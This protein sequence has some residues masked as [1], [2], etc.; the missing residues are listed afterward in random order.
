MP[1]NNSAPYQAIGGDNHLEM[2]EA[3]M[4]RSPSF[5]A[6][7][8]PSRK[9]FA[10]SFGARLV[11]TVGVAAFLVIL[12]TTAVTSGNI[13]AVPQTLLATTSF[14]TVGTLSTGFTATDGSANTSWSTARSKLIRYSSLTAD[15]KKAEFVRYKLKFGRSYATDEE[16]QQRYSVFLSNLERIDAMNDDVS[17]AAYD[18]NEFAD[19]THEEFKKYKTGYSSTKSTAQLPGEVADWEDSQC[20]AC[21]RYPE[22]ADYT[23]ENLPT[24]FDWRDYGAVTKIKNQGMCGSC[25]SFS[26]TGDVEGSWYLAGNN[27]TSLAEQQLVAC[28]S[29]MDNGCNG[30]LPLLA[31]MYL[32]KAGGIVSEDDYP[33]MK[34]NQYTDAVDAPNCDVSIVQKAN[35]AAHISSW[36]RISYSANTEDEMALALIR[37]GPLSAAL[38]ATGM[39]YYSG[40][41]D[42]Y[43]GCSTSL[44]HAVLI[45][46]FGEED[47]V[48]YWT[49]KN[50]WGILWGEEGT[51]RLKRGE[52]TC[53]IATEVVHSLV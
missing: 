43:S 46:G 19:M 15:L 34:A 52:N 20:S 25:W 30:G 1:V 2:Q 49:I 16:E 31:M 14:E 21:K 7:P 50:S 3:G 22:M 38:D 27:L 32:E 13:G 6:P 12:G 4:K 39:E 26:T 37:S 48:K 45:V 33:Y 29:T 36:Q 5:S 8:S 18:I 35:Y 44:N 28:D 9:G 42:D 23:M 41:V 24:N 10:S 17:T 40:G 51:Y 47:G 53:G 11:I